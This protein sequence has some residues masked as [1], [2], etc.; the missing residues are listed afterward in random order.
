MEKKKITLP[1]IVE[2]RYDKNTL[3]QIFD[4]T[5]ITTDGFG[6]FNSTEK[7]GLIRRLAER[8]GVIL[9]TDSDAGGVQIRSFLSGILPKD[10]I[11]HLYVPQIKG[12][13]RRKRAPSRTGIL[14]VEGMNREVLERVLSPF[15]ETADKTATNT[16][17]C[18][19]K[20]GFTGRRVTKF[21]FFV[22]GLSGGVSSSVLREALARELMLPPTMSAGALLE[23]INL[24]YSYEEYK[25]KLESVKERLN[26]EKNG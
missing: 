13:E 23:A 26:E 4:A 19:E 9:L 24:L 1:I 2:G 25:E 16:G 3:L 18:S 6:I 5:V 10:K 12:K 15:I 8:G 11:F 14:G 20:D 7:Q 17:A 22:D 21:D